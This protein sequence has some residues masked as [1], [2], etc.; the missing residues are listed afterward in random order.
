MLPAISAPSDTLHR[1]LDQSLGHA[2]E[3]GAG[4]SSHLPMALAALDAMGAGAARLQAFFAAYSRRLAPRPQPP[5]GDPADGFDRIDGLGR[6]AGIDDARAW[7]ALRGQPGAYLLLERGFAAALA[8]AGRDALLRAAL[9]GLVTGV[10]AAAFHG[11]IRTAHAVESRHAGELAAALGYWASRWMPVDPPVAAAGASLAPAAWL[12]ALDAQRLAADA[13]WAPRADMISDRMREASRTQAYRTLA[14]RSGIDTDPAAWLAAIAA[15]AAVR[16]RRTRNFTVLHLCTG[17]RAARVLAPWLL[18]QG[19]TL[20]PLAH[21]MAAASLAS[22]V[23]ADVV[24]TDHRTAAS[25][26]LDWPDVIARA[27]ASDDEHVIKLVHAMLA[28]A[29]ADPGPEWLSAA[30]AAVATRDGA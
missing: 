11:V 29:A 23:A 28:Q 14:G 26:S 12:D 18:A 8:G 21:A 20:A 25:P 5:Q 1:L 22:N 24:G 2:P 6:V 4:L 15:A 10:G 7:H 17:A 27:C 3:Y 13:A 9:P 19:A 30:N 16:Y